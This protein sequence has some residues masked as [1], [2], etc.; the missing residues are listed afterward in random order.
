L[1]TGGLYLANCDKDLTAYFSYVSTIQPS[2][3]EYNF[4]M[5]DAFEN[6]ILFT[7]THYDNLFTDCVNDVV[8]IELDLLGLGHKAAK[9]PN[10]FMNA[11]FVNMNWGIPNSGGRQIIYS[12][13][14]KSQ[15]W[16]NTNPN[17]IVLFGGGNYIDPMYTRLGDLT[18]K[19]LPDSFSLV[20][21][22]NLL[23]AN[24]A[25]IFFNSDVNAN[26]SLLISRIINTQDSGKSGL[27]AEYSDCLELP[28]YDKK[29][30][31]VIGANDQEVLYNSST[32]KNCYYTCDKLNSHISS[33]TK[34]C[35]RYVYTI[36]S[37]SFDKMPTWFNFATEKLSYNVNGM[38][39]QN[40]QI[41]DDKNATYSYHGDSQY[42]SVKYPHVEA[43]ASQIQLQVSDLQVAD[44]VDKIGVDL[45]L[46]ESQT[47]NGLSS[48]AI[49]AKTTCLLIP[50]KYGWLAN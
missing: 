3:K 18:I 36:V 38:T 39:N 23:S 46:A 40:W 29:R 8:F 35:Y 9:H 17:K 7:A 19:N 2:Y 44:V 6:Y 20:K 47:V 43:E 1:S 34:I 28:H 5:S 21:Y 10:C 13:I 32:V 48:F 25:L 16:D 33:F 24:N 14:G 12:V 26:R 27:I 31:C 49:E 41:L 45:A 42:I 50:T 15:E 22:T 4:A 37:P 11:V 30:G